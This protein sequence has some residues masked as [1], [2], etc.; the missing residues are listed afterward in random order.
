MIT[1]FNFFNM[2]KQKKV[3]VTTRMREDRREKL[4]KAFEES[5]FDTKD[6]YIEWLIDYVH[7]YEPEIK[8]KEVEVEVEKKLEPN[9]ILITLNPVQMFILREHVSRAPDFAVKQNKIIDKLKN[10]PWY[11]SSDLY[12]PNFQELWVRN[13]ELTE[14]MTEIEK[15][16]VIK[17]N[18]SAFLLN[19]FLTNLID[20]N[21]YN[22]DVNVDD[23]E[24]F[25]QNQIETSKPDEDEHSDE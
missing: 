14:E 9:Q 12:N 15:E 25:I 23:I 8:I 17:H 4:E 1:N 7:N 22:S 11:A 10:K 18:M 13:I 20:G 5:N 6:E 21:I 3:P 2:N 19:V 24:L 16:E